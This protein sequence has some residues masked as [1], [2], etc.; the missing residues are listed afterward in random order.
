VVDRDLLAVDD[1]LFAIGDALVEIA[2]RLTLVKRVLLVV[3]VL[4]VGISVHGVS[5][6][7]FS[8]IGGCF[9]A[10]GRELHM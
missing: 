8:L 4:Y 9:K 2:H 3:V 10:Q 1:Y 7:W 6:R 5:L